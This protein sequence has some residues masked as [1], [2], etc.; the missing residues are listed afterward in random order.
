MKSGI[1]IR[2]PWRKPL[3]RWRHELRV[4]FA[5]QPREC[6]TRSLRLRIAVQLSDTSNSCPMPKRY[7][8]SGICIQN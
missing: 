3:L 7:P 4:M 6:R 5:I 2:N 1:D 8:S